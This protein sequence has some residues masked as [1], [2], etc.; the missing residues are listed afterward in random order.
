MQQTSVSWW[1][2][3][4]LLRQ[5]L[6]SFPGLANLVY[7]F[8]GD[9]LQVL[10][11]RNNLPHV[12]TGG[13]DYTHWWNKW[14]V[15]VYPG[16]ITLLPRSLHVKSCRD[17][18]IIS[19]G[20]QEKGG[21]PLIRACSVITSNTVYNIPQIVNKNTVIM[22]KLIVTFNLTQSVILLGCDTLMESPM[23][24]MSFLPGIDKYLKW[25]IRAGYT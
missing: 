6:F 16:C 4:T 14:Y 7:F 19:S 13:K 9:C 10:G 21:C 24:E 11:F 8:K 22:L 5:I 3:V 20:F 18:L 1:L 12:F 25:L 15:C 2:T 23:V 17:R